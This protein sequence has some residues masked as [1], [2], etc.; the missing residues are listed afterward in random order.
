MTQNNT[1][2]PRCQC[3]STCTNPPG[4]PPLPFCSE[5]RNVCP[6]KSPTNG[7]EPLYEPN[8]WNQIKEYLS[9]HNCFA[10]AFNFLDASL[11]GRCRENEKDGR[12]DSPFHQ[13]GSA[14][15]ASPFSSKVLKT[16][17]NLYSRLKGD[18]PSMKPSTFE[19]PCKKGFS[20]I[21]LVNDS[22]QDYHFYRRD[23][24]TEYYS[25]KHGSLPVSN[26][27]A[28]GYYIY[29]VELAN[30]NWSRK[31]DPLNYDLFCGYYCIPRDR[32]LHLKVGG[33]KTL[34]RSSRRSSRSRSKRR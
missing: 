15:G 32:P 13:P 3:L 23:G 30:H 20:K 6:R 9:T 24:N 28:L 33:K 21:A 18:V 12:C 22:D 25:D 11:M 27:D 1:K 10:Y 5:H 16:C 2:S 8:R 34:R 4:P 14:S 31:D 19:E 7:W 26:L 17:P 29:D